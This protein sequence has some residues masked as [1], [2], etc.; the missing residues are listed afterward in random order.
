MNAQ[1][2]KTKL[3]QSLLQNINIIQIWLPQV[4]K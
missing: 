4:K 2:F 1:V 3:A